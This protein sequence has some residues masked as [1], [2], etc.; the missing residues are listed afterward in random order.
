MGCIL[1]GVEKI[2][3]KQLCRKCY[4]RLWKRRKKRKE[5]LEKYKTAVLRSR[6]LTIYENLGLECPQCRNT[7]EFFVD[8]DRGEIAC[9]ICGLI[10][11]SGVRFNTFFP[12]VE[13]RGKFNGG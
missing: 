10:L 9:K 1:C 6:S 7:R 3:A 2:Y 12:Y 8:F 5:K 11:V 4:Q 13:R